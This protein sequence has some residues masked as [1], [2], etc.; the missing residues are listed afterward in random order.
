MLLCS[1]GWSY[2]HSILLLSMILDFQTQTHLF[3]KTVAFTVLV[4][5]N[6][7]CRFVEFDSN[8]FV[9]KEIRS[10]QPPHDDF[11]QQRLGSWYYDQLKT[12]KCVG[13]FPLIN[14]NDS[15]KF[16]RHQRQ[17]LHV[18]YPQL[19]DTEIRLKTIKLDDICVTLNTNMLTTRI[20]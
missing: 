7:V 20:L 10:A 16:E 18:I 11:Q 1:S 15:E 19:D 2:I 9:R 4:A 14:K 6:V 3:Q 8:N 5:G 13:W 12:P 17:C